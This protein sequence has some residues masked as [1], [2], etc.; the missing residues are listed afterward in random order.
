MYFMASALLMTSPY[1]ALM[2]KRLASCGPSWR[3]PTHSR[4]TMGRKPFCTAS[5]ADAR[6]QPDV[7]Q[8]V[9]STVSTPMAVRVAASE[10]PK[11]QLA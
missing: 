6:M 3:S 8:P 5:T 1:F 9:I 7:V 4:M 10:V 2:S 11:K